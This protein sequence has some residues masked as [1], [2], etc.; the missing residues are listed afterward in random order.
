MTDVII[1]RPAPMSAWLHAENSCS[2]TY[3]NRLYNPVVIGSLGGVIKRKSILSVQ[4]ALASEGISLGWSVRHDVINQ[5]GSLKTITTGTPPALK[6]VVYEQLVRPYRSMADFKRLQDAGVIVLNPILR[7][8]ASA[9]DQYMIK[10]GTH[11]ATTHVAMGTRGVPIKP[12][13]RWDCYGMRN[14]FQN[15]AS[16]PLFYNPGL[17][18]S[19]PSEWQDFYAEHYRNAELGSVFETVGAP[20]FHALDLFLQQQ[21][22]YQPLVNGVLDDL[23]SGAMDVLTELGELPETVS[24]LYSVLRRLVQLFLGLKSK[25]V[26]ARKKFKGKELI[27][28]LA[29]LW[30]QFRYAASPLA[31]SFADGMELLNAQTKEYQSKR[32]RVDAPFEF[33]KG[34]YTYKGTIEARVFGKIKI[35]VSSRVANMGLNPVKTLWELTPLSFVVDWV[36]PIGEWLGALMV[37]TSVTQTALQGSIRVRSVEVAHSEYGPVRTSFNYYRATPL[38]GATKPFPAPFLDWKRSLDSLALAW[39]LFLKQHWKS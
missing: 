36:I 31:Y 19:F 27:D 8:S 34:E 15:S 12:A 25:E 10:K 2:D 37:P 14:Y 13:A 21:D 24:Y 18:T 28:E 3:N 35:D 16:Y 5:L 23:Y 30:M 38:E 17:S 29:S 32:A 7:V 11:V 22:Q 4:N 9:S 33:S 6:D 1:F 26:L 20:N 39:G